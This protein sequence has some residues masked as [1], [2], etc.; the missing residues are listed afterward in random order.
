MKKFNIQD[1]LKIPIQITITDTTNFILSRPLRKS[2]KC[3]LLHMGELIGET[4]GVL[5][6]TKMTWNETF[7]Y[8]VK[9]SQINIPLNLEIFKCLNNK[10]VFVAYATITINETIKSVELFQNSF[11][12]IKIEKENDYLKF[13]QAKVESETFRYEK[14]SVELIASIVFFTNC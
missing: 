1:H 2:M 4:F 8:V 7:Y 14:N 10:D 13:I 6:N 5:Q 3:R 12:N 9:K 11:L